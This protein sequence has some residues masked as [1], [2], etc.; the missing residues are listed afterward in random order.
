MAQNF[1]IEI[2]DTKSGIKDNLS[3]SIADDEWSTLLEFKQCIDKLNESDAMKSGLKVNYGFKYNAG[4]GLKLESSKPSDDVV[5]ILLHR[6]RPVILQNE[7]T[8]F[9]K[10][11]NILSKNINHPKFHEIIKGI[12][13]LYSGNH[14]QKQIVIKTNDV[15]LNSDDVLMKWLNAHEYHRDEDKKKYIEE[16]HKALP[17][18]NTKTIYISMIIDKINASLCLSH[19]I[20]S[21]ELREGTISL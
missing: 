18:E 1:D 6:L 9:Y 21:L 7:K 17:F 4:E 3:I 13:D 14:F 15:I 16:L 12:R 11:C 19:I 2:S 8:N 20:R 5:A 10:V